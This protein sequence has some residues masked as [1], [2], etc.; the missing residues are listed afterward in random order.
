MKI[1]PNPAHNSV[2][3]QGYEDGKISV[4]ISSLVGQTILTDK[5]NN[6]SKIDLSVLDPGIYIMEAKEGNNVIS[7]KLIKQ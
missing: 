5:I 6:G 7:T 4:K 1:Y 3:V 2:F